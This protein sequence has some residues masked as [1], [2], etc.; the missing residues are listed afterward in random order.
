MR[1]DTLTPDDFKVEGQL[2][3]RAIRVLIRVQNLVA[4]RGSYDYV[5]IV[6]YLGRA[7]QSHFKELDCGSAPSFDFESGMTPDERSRA[8]Q[9]SA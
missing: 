2:G 4:A 9:V 3:S 6:S 1:A 7:L 8:A 5:A